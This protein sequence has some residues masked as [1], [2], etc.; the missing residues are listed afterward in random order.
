MDPA[1]VQHLIHGESERRLMAAG[2]MAKVL[3][4]AWSKLRCSA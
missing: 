1:E 2:D 4:N 3:P